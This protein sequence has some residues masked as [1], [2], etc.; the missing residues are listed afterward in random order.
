MDGNHLCFSLKHAVVLSCAVG[1][2]GSPI[3]MMT[4]NHSARL[5]RLA[6]GRSWETIFLDTDTIPLLI[7]NF[8]KWGS[9]T[10]TSIR[11]SCDLPIVDQV[12]FL[13]KSGRCTW[14]H[15]RQLVLHFD[16]K[17]LFYPPLSK[18]AL[19]EVKPMLLRS[20]NHSWPHEAHIRDDLVCGEPVTVN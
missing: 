2:D 14:C 16:L 7:I 5:S 10:L 11:W 15:A 4:I 12:W 13:G 18:S 8:P 9:P 19:V 20:N 6:R 3:W 17:L 1:G